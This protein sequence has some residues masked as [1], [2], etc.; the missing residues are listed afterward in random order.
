MFV[1]LGAAKHTQGY[2]SKREIDFGV[3][4]CQWAKIMTKPIEQSI[5]EITKQECAYQEKE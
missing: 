1:A 3:T 2:S 4:F 5:R